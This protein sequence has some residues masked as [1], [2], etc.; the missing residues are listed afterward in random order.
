MPTPSTQSRLDDTAMLVTAAKKGLNNVRNA[1]AAISLRLVAEHG[2]EANSYSNYVSECLQDALVQVCRG[3]P[4]MQGSA[5]ADRIIDEY[6][7][8]Y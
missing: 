1:T 8:H 5:Q 7:R 4:Y 6:P 3:N 2:L